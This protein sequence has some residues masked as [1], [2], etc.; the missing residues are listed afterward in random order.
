MIP[1]RRFTAKNIRATLPGLSEEEEAKAYKIRAQSMV[2]LRVF[3]PTLIRASITYFSRK[4][5]HICELCFDTQGNLTDARCSCGKGSK[6]VSCAHMGAALLVAGDADDRDYE[7]ACKPGRTSMAAIRSLIRSIANNFSGYRLFALTDAIVE[8]NKELFRF[9]SDVRELFA[10]ALR[11]GIFHNA[12]DEDIAGLLEGARLVTE[13][14]SND[15]ED[16]KL[17]YGVFLPVLSAETGHRLAMEMLS[18]PILKESLSALFV[19]YYDKEREKLYM[20][21]AFYPVLSWK[22]LIYLDKKQLTRFFGIY[23]GTIEEFTYMLK[24]YKDH[25]DEDAIKALVNNPSFPKSLYTLLPIDEGQRKSLEEE[26]LLDS[27][28]NVT[29]KAFLMEMVKLDPA[30]LT[31]NPAYLQMAKAKG[32]EKAFAF[33]LGL[34]NSQDLMDLP[35]DELLAILSRLDHLD[36]SAMEVLRQRLDLVPNL[37]LREVFRDLPSIYKDFFLA[38]YGQVGLSQ[39]ETLTFAHKFGVTEELGFRRYGPCTF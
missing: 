27:L 1:S 4:T 16:Q 35:L 15:N 8:S 32:C 24:T 38:H 10:L 21:L 31:N 5:E 9:P 2:H 7:A 14:Y 11:E 6:E 26:A 33:L 30:R 12:G 37:Y 13:N 18:S 28:K 36:E 22:E 17:W 23:K 39:S 3:S 34:G 20:P 25:L 19:D 29:N